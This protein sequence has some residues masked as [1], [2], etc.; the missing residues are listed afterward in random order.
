MMSSR[1]H[2]ALVFTAVFAVVVLAA[3]AVYLVRSTPE[4]VLPSGEAPTATTPPSTSTT[5]VTYTVGEG[6]SAG[7]IATDLEERGVIDSAK[8]FEYFAGLTG[9]SGNLAA[10][11]HELRTGLSVVAAV[12]AVTVKEEVPV[13]RVT[14]P[15]GMR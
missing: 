15:E 9:V 7:D 6:A 10:G 8:Q 14:F 5:T 4:R 1:W 3:L 11:D 12:D 2:H 13:L